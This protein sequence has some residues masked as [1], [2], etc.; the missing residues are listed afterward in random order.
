MVSELD[1]AIIVE[2]A[3]VKRL[4]GELAQANMNLKVLREAKRVLSGE[5]T[6]PK[7]KPTIADMVEDMLRRAGSLHMDDIVKGLHQRGI[8]AAK[9]TVTTALARYDAKKRRFKR[10]A[11]NTFALRKEM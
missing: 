7:L 10:I 8:K 11:P 1:D 2:E 4:R 5:R 3:R 6:P 9:T